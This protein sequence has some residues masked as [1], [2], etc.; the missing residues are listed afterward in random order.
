MVQKIPRVTLDIFCYITLSVLLP[1]SDSDYTLGIFCSIT[2]SVLLRLSHS[3]YTLDICN[4]TKD[5]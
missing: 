2:L 5:T 4:G 1:L 3:D